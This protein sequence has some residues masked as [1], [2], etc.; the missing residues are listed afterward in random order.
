MSKTSPLR[1]ARPHAQDPWDDLPVSAGKDI[2][3]EGESLHF[4]LFTEA[5][6]RLQGWGRDAAKPKKIT[7]VTKS[8]TT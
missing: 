4:D 5:P 1:P 7:Q 8:T 2:W 6:P 3:F